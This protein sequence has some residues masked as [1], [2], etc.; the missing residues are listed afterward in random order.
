[1]SYRN[2]EAVLCDSQIRNYMKN[3]LFFV[4]FCLLFL[5]TACGGEQSTTTTPHTQAEGAASVPEDFLAFYDR[6]M[7]DSV[8][9][10]EHIQFPLAGAPGMSR[11]DVPASGFYWQAEDWR[12]HRYVADQPFEFTF[13]PVSDDL[14][15]EEIEH[16]NGQYAAE[17]RFLRDEDGWKLIFYAD[18]YLT[19][20]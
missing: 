9:Q 7:T 5:L 11:P 14:I 2:S 10:R 1:M 6:F 16:E 19:G 8:F 12:V 4:G 18:L 13:I 17:R 20:E 15:I 3:D